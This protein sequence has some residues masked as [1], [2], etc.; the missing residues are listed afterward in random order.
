MR[1]N[2]PKYNCVLFEIS[3]DLTASLEKDADI[4]ILANRTHT[5]D[6]RDEREGGPLV[7]LFGSKTKA[8]GVTHRVRGR[9]I[10]SP[11]PTELKL[12]LL[13]SSTRA[14][15]NLRPPPRSFR[16][17]SKLVQFATKHLGAIPVSCHAV[18]EYD[19]RK[20]YRPKAYFPVPLML[21]EKPDG[22]THLESATFSRRK[23]DGIDYQ[24][25]VDRH[26]DSELFTHIVS[27]DSTLEL[28][29]RTIASLVERAH[30]IS[31]QLVTRLGGD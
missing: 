19:Q 4:Q 26:D 16:P 6:L 11:G 31:E 20:G 25:A 27:F 21:V 12:A 24:I 15:E 30:S 3:S 2:L 8:R 1:L 10:I 23:S 18:F 22:I 5:H 13:V 14:S 17:V 7:A 9:L 29:P 28:S